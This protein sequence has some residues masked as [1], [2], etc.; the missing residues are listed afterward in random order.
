MVESCVSTSP[1]LL[2]QVLSVWTAAGAQHQ[3]RIVQLDHEEMMV[4]GEE[5]ALLVP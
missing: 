5:G 3:M 1:P 2:C 4:L